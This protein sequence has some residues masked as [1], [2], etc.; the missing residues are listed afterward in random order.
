MGKLQR[1]I[2]VTIL[3]VISVNA[4]S[5]PAIREQAPDFS[6][7]NIKGN[8]VKLSDYIGE[9]VLVDFWASWCGPC[10]KSNPNLLRLYNKY[11]RKGFEIFGVSIDE[12][13]NALKRAIVADKMSWVQVHESG[14][15]EGPVASSWKV[16]AIPASYLLDRSGKIAGIN[17][18][19]VALETKILELLN[20]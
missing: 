17:L 11:K 2:I 20:Q 12:D 18:Q 8:L 13:K 15:W 7:P 16:E 4:L 14:G 1:L 9:V 5:Q 6:L 19:G 10:R 3:S